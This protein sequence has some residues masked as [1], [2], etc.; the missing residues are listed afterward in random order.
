M[1][2]VFKMGK[3]KSNGKDVLP[4]P[5]SPLSDENTSPPRPGTS[6][7]E[8]LLMTT[9]QQASEQYIKA[10]RAERAYRSKKHATL[11]RANYNEAKAH[12]REAVSHFKLGTQGIFSVT[13]EVPYM[14]GHWREQQ[15]RK[16]EAKKREK[17]IQ[18][19]Q[20]IEEVL[21]KGE[22]E[23]ERE[24]EPEKLSQ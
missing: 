9:R 17:T 6:G 24:D 14:L 1:S 11:A 19:K 2:S 18:R 22:A 20:R 4:S 12:F 3:S 15:R 5:P 16:A 21:A 7:T 13:K 10:Q 8:D 23:E